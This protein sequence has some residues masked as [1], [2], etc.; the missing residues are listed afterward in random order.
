MLPNSCSLRTLY[1]TAQVRKDPVLAA[2][3]I[4]LKPLAMAEHCRAHLAPP[5][6]PWHVNSHCIGIQELALSYS[7]T[8]NLCNSSDAKQAQTRAALKNVNLAK[9]PA[10]TGETHQKPAAR[11]V[12]HWATFTAH[13]TTQVLV[14]THECFRFELGI[15]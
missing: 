15:E 6:P 11:L 12:G 7:P 2:Q 14:I 10:V 5:S 13:A 4:C 8:C 1:E 9:W 3:W